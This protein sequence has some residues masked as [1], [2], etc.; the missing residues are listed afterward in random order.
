MYFALI[1]SVTLILCCS[2]CFSL[3]IILLGLTLTNEGGV[4]GGHAGVLVDGEEGAGG[5]HEAA[6]V[7]ARGQHQA[8]PLVI[9]GPGLKTRPG[10]I[11]ALR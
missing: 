7:G 3:L 8:R 11:P 5:L 6:R 9:E 2:Q 10:Q 4:P 1:K